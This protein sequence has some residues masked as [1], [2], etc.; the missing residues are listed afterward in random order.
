MRPT[1][2]GSA[3]SWSARAIF[4]ASSEPAVFAARAQAQVDAKPCQVRAVG[5]FPVLFRIAAT[6]SSR[7][8]TPGCFQYHSNTHVPTR[9]SGG[10]PSRASSS[11]WAPARW[12]RL[13]SPNWTACLSALIMSAPCGR[14]TMT[15]GFAA[16]ALMRYAE[17][18]VV[19]SGTR[20]APSLVPP[21]LDAAF[22][23]PA[24]SVWPNA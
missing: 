5:T 7:C 19:P 24:C 4:G 16:C 12:N 20:S 14:K 18:S 9:A 8:G 3:R 10:R 17:K 11:C 23:R 6:N 2:G 22:S 21:S 1:S 13:S 15:S